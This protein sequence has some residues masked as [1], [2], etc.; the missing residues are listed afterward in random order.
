[1]Q[2]LI[3]CLHAPSTASVSWSNLKSLLFV[4][5]GGRIQ[6]HCAFNN[7]YAWMANRV[8]FAY[9]FICRSSG[10]LTAEDVVNNMS[11]EGLRSIIK[12]YG[13][14]KRAREIARA[15]VDSRYAFGRL[16]TTSQLANIVA[17][18]YSG[19]VARRFNSFKLQQTR[20][21]FKL[22]LKLDFPLVCGKRR[23]FCFERNVCLRSVFSVLYRRWDLNDK[24]IN[25]MRRIFVC[26]K[27]VDS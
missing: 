25:R 26:W 9:S 20:V 21:S 7:E 17:S 19:Y 13:E 22:K 6:R 27:L 23:R 10:R 24:S 5:S 11:E 12:T 15:I 4:L 16:K 3:A 1:M 14:E 8:H 18:V 2:Y